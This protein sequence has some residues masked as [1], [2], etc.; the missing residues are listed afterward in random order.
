MLSLCVYVSVC[1]CASL[2]LSL[3]LSLSF[4]PFSI[5]GLFFE[6]SYHSKFKKITFAIRSMVQNGLCVILPNN[7]K[8]KKFDKP[9]SNYFFDS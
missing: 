2:S 9:L 8:K 1:V 6:K 3:S 5:L 7:G 4:L